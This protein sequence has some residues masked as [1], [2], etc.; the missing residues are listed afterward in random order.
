MFGKQRGGVVGPQG[1][2]FPLRIRQ[3]IPTSCWVSN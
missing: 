3:I 1:L 2:F